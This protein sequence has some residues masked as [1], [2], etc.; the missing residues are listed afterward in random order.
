[1]HVC[2]GQSEKIANDKVKMIECNATDPSPS[3]TITLTFKYKGITRRNTTKTTAI[4]TTI[5]QI[6]INKL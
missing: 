3:T 1:M 2:T 6:S 5:K 4:S